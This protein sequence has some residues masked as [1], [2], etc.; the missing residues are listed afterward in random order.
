MAS[1]GGAAG[2]V[3]WVLVV[4]VGSAVP[5]LAAVY[6]VGEAS[7]WTIGADYSTWTSDKT[8]SVGDSLVFNYGSGHTVDEVSESDYKTCTVGNALTTDSSGA[9]TVALK[10]AGT[11]YFICGVVG[12]CG[13]G[14][15][16]AVTVAAAG[17]PSTTPSSGSASP[18][19]P[20]TT[21][22]R[23][24]PTTTVTTP[25]AHNSPA[26][27]S[28]SQIAGPSPLVATLTVSWIALFKFVL[29]WI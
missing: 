18:D 19:A 2:A 1:V 22:S 17:G 27:M 5:S 4:L 12:H 16:L 3:C 26:S 20:T 7:G 24:P 28:S 8:F 21:T 13:S 29:R 15:K 11:H 9:T 14:M 10:T 23:A 6:T 25:S